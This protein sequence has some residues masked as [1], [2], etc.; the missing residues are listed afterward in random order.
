MLEE[1]ARNKRRSVMVILFFVV[2]WGGIGALLGALLTA[3]STS[4]R[5][6]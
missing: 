5:R 2:I 3:N 6:A 4:A 1:I